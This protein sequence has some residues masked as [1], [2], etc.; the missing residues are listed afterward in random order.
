MNSW[1]G[2]RTFPSAQFSLGTPHCNW[3]LSTGPERRSFGLQELPSQPSRYWKTSAG[4]APRIRSQSRNPKLSG[5][6]QPKSPSTW[7]EILPGGLGA[8][9]RSP[10]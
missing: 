10:K 8:W 6:S 2:V 5:G 3:Q 1:P 9:G 7:A 4:L